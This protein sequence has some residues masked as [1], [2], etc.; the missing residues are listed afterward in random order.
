MAESA[1]ST[2]QT[3]PTYRIGAVAKL[4]GIPG[5]TLRIWVRRYSVVTP[6]RTETGARLYTRDD[7]DRLS[8]IKRLVDFGD[9]IGAV[10][11]LS[12]E[13]LEQRLSASAPRESRR[14]RAYSSLVFG[15]G[16]LPYSASSPRL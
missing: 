4:T 8:L 5:D 3:E 12:S 10:A 14:Y 7:V 9:A 16:E 6:R 1:Q 11:G 15:P 2:S 13:Q